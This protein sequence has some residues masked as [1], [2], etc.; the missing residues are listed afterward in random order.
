M[1]CYAYSCTQ[2][3]L[4]TQCMLLTQADDLL[5]LQLITV[6]SQ[7]FLSRLRFSFDSPSYICCF[8]NEL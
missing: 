2:Y 6:G 5:S 8:R 3:V 4:H 1:T 7:F